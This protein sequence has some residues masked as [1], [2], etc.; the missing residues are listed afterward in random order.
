MSEQIYDV[1]TR[2]GFLQRTVETTDRRVPQRF[3]G[4]TA[5]GNADLTAWCEAFAPGCRSVLIL[6]PTGVGKTYLAYGAIRDLA[7]RG[8]SVKW[9][10]LTAPDMYA[11][12]RPR[13][14]IDGEGEFQTIATAEM[15]LLDDLGAAKAT[16]WTEEV[17]YRLVNYRY[18]RGLPMLIT[19]NLPAV[20]ADGRPSLKA[21]LG[22]RVMSRLTE[23]CQYVI[24]RGPDRRL[25]P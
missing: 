19:S 14:G 6:G 11:R 24:L 3:R 23:M 4:G 12:L 13:D 10:A 22:E 2:E 16:E 15:L 8:V 21:S 25:R 17:N 18:D 20:A 1:T 9:L 5:R 7:A